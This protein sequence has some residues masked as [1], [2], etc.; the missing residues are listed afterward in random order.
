M[1]FSQV[2]PKVPSILLKGRTGDGS[3]FWKFGGWASEC[4]E[5]A[6][7]PLPDKHTHPCGMWS[8]FGKTRTQPRFSK[9]RIDEDSREKDDVIW[10]LHCVYVMKQNCQF[11]SD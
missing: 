11:C 4:G 2:F 9:V 8:A 7:P 5:T 6:P 1:V 10:R 3:R